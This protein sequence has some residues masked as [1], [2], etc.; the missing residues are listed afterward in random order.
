MSKFDSFADPVDAV[1]GSPVG[2]FGL[3]VLR[4]FYAVAQS[5]PVIQQI[6]LIFFSVMVASDVLL[7]LLNALLNASMAS[8]T[9]VCAMTVFVNFCGLGYIFSIGSLYP[10]VG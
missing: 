9:L 1:N 3:L 5:L 4:C 8:I 2:Q 6:L 7:F 10:K